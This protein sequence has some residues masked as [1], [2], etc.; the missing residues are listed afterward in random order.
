MLGFG[1]RRTNKESLRGT[2]FPIIK[3]KTRKLEGKK[4]LQRTLRALCNIRLGPVRSG[5]IHGEGSGSR[6]VGLPAFCYGDS[7]RPR[8]IYTQSMRLKIEKKF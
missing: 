3:E 6:H 4:Y 2:L 5:P 1:G 7:K 8:I